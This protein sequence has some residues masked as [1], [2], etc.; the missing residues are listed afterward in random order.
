M[1]QPAVLFRQVLFFEIESRPSR[2]NPRLVNIQVNQDIWPAD[3]FPHIGDIGMF[4]GHMASLISGR[5]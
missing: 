4:L 3:S 2:A 1:G 5:A